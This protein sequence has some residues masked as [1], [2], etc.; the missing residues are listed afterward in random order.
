MLSSRPQTLLEKALAFGSHSAVPH[1]SSEES[2]SAKVLQSEQYATSSQHVCLVLL[3]VGGSIVDEGVRSKLSE[4]VKELVAVEGRLYCSLDGILGRNVKRVQDGLKRV[5]EAMETEGRSNAKDDFST[6][7]KKR[8][9]IEVCALWCVC[10]CLC[11][12]I[13]G[14]LVPFAHC[15]TSCNVRYWNCLMC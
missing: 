10:V 14:F 4:A 2:S 11:T 7:D 15:N 6:L 9:W 8:K 3:N 5:R 1:F 12:V 13:S